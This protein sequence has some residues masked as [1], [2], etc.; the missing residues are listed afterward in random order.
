MALALSGWDGPGRFAAGP[1]RSWKSSSDG[2]ADQDPACAGLGNQ[3]AATN[4]HAPAQCHA[5]FISIGLSDGSHIHSHP[6][7][8]SR[9]RRS[10]GHA[11]C[12]FADTDA[13]ATYQHSNLPSDGATAESAARND[14]ANDERSAS[15][16]PSGGRGMGYGGWLC[17]GNLATGRR[18]SGMGCSCGLA[19]LPGPG[20]AGI[21][22]SK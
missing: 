17:P 5:H 18:L 9:H 13:P 12:P 10:N 19:G 22:L 20:N 2:Y 6:A 7:C 1:V 8:A 21:L 16:S 14:H 3:H 4:A 15:A 11:A